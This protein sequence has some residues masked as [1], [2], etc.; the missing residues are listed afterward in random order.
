MTRL[1]SSFGLLASLS[2]WLVSCAPP[3]TF[4][5]QRP[6]ELAVQPEIEYLA[7][8]EFQTAGGT[9][10]VN[11]LPAL[12]SSLFGTKTLKPVAPTLQAF[13]ATPEA[14][15][16]IQQLVRAAVVHQLSL[17]SPYQLINTSGEV[18]GYTGVVPEA[19]TVAV[20]EATIRFAEERFEGSEPY[21][22]LAMIQNKGIGLEQQLLASAG[23]AVVEST[24]TGKKLPAPYV[25]HLAALEVEFRLV[26]LSNRE[27]LAKSSPIRAFYAGKWGGKSDT[28]HLPGSTA[29]RIR[30]VFQQDEALTQELKT[31]AARAQLAVQDPAEYLAQGYNLKQ[32][33]RVPLSALDIRA[34]VAEQVAVAYARKVSP[35]EETA[36][37][38][39]QD[40]DAAAAT[41]IRGNAY[42]EAIARIQGLN[43]RTAADS[44]NLGLAYEAS[45]QRQLARQAY[46][47]ADQA[48]PGN[49]LYQQALQRVR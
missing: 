46:Q 48:D 39:V 26:R 20:L 49:S 35:Y 38:A 30:Q 27:E 40:G 42:E 28:S 15:A 29:L 3:V 36:T 6:A 41:L 18:E 37:L 43:T 19:A 24:G 33:K 32:S 1:A 13:Q 9:I 10:A 44:Y 16:A 8:G 31:G 22:F 7:V 11:E 5:V 25:E 4:Q 14:G 17:H 2:L 34:R 23:S 45:G 12:Q 21:N 47:Q